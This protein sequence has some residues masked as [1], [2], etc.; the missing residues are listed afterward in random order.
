M[1]RLNTLIALLQEQAA[2]HGN[3]NCSITIWDKEGG[4]DGVWMSADDAPP[5]GDA[6]V[7]N[8]MDGVERILAIDFGGCK[9]QGN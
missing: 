6:N 9:M 5:V 7:I 3:I 4:D 1:I 8:N 2:K